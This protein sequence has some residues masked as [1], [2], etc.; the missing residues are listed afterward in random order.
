MRLHN[1]VKKDLDLRRSKQIA[2][3]L[4]IQQISCY[5]SESQV[6]QLFACKPG[7]HM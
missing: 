6:C 3:W 5:E 2:T 7:E 4:D 1:E